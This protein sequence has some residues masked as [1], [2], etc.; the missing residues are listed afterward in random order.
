MTDDADPNYVCICRAQHLRPVYLLLATKI[1]A[2][3]VSRAKNKPTRQIQISTVLESCTV[4]SMFG[5]WTV[6]L[7]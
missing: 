6:I 5:H 3:H 2:G 1:T 7:V 4:P